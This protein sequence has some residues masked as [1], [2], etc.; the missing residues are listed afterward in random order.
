MPCDTQMR[1]RPSCL[2]S[3]RFLIVGDTGFVPSIQIALALQRYVDS[4]AYFLSVAIRLRAMRT[5]LLRLCFLA[6]VIVLVVNAQIATSKLSGLSKC[7]Y[8]NANTCLPSPQTNPL[9]KAL[10]L[11]DFQR[12]VG[13]C[14]MMG[15][16]PVT[17]SSGA[18]NPA[19]YIPTSAQVYIYIYISQ[20]QR[21]STTAL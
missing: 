14:S 20:R 4:F 11:A 7:K 10:G 17:V 19:M 16:T 18:S 2:Q 5:L 15:V 1:T 21:S 13:M 12:G 8:S 3:I 9:S 6:H